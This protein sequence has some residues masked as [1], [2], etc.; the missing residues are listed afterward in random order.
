[1]YNSGIP[2]MNPMNFAGNN[3][4]WKASYTAINQN[5]N[6]NSQFIPDQSSGK[7]N[8]VFKTSILKNTLFIYI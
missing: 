6:N 8:F 7:M 3:I 1:M 2:F 5:Q 4:D